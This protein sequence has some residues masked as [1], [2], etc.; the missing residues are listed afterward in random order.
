MNSLMSMTKL[1]IFFQIHTDNLK[2][3]KQ[4]PT[5]I[6]RYIKRFSV[7]VPKPMNSYFTLK[8]LSEDVDTS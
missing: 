4:P 8:F 2:T 1:K 5:I 6:P 3:F 7:V